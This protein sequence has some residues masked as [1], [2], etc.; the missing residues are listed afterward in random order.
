[1]VARFF[2]GYAPLEVTRQRE[3]AT[4]LIFLTGFKYL[5]NTLVVLN[6][7]NQEPSRNSFLLLIL[8]LKKKEGFGC[9]TLGIKTYHFRHPA[10]IA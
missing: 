8:P 10:S 1:M 7:N 5:K 3:V 4:D 9:S 6:Q 2:K